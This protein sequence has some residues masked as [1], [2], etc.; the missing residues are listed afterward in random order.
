[1]S[2]YDLDQTL[3]VFKETLPEALLPF[4]LPQLADLC[5]RGEVTPLFY[6]GRYAIEVK[7]YIDRPKS[8][9]EKLSGFYS[10]YLTHERLINL[11][12]KNTDKLFF[13]SAIAY[14]EQ[15]TDAWDG[16]CYEIVLKANDIN[17]NRFLNDENYSLYKDDDP[18]PVTRESLLFPSKQVKSYIASKQTAEQDTTEQNTPKQQRI[19]ELVE[20][21]TEL[22]VIKKYNPDTSKHL[23]TTPAINI[24][25]EVI[26]E[27]W[28]DYDPDQPAPK[29]STITSW[30]TNNFEG[31]SSALALNI[32]KV[33]RH[34]SAKSGGKFKR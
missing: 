1:M 13:N 22:E 30:I 7:E 11:L 17:L 12:H 15:K 31:T 14:E 26:T 28:V 3:K 10:G 23:Y 29:Q 16:A 19:A 5:R 33:C 20:A 4:D 18:F 8:A 21:K 6:Y 34:S 25:N 9:D 32:D 24:M 27:F 2:Y